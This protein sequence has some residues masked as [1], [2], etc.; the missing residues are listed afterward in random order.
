MPT[1]YFH[2]VDGEIIGESTGGVEINYS[3]DALGSVT[4][5]PGRR[6]TREHLHIQAVWGA[7]REDRRGSGPEVR[8]GGVAGVSADGAVAERLLR[9]GAAPWTANRNVDGGR[10]LWP[11]EASYCYGSA[12]PT[13]FVDPTGTQ[14][15]IFGE[16]WIE[17]FQRKVACPQAGRS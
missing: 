6:S 14:I 15:I 7:A 5:T 11:E 3:T 1:T 4:G 9:Q 17:F 2:T 16:P 13:C 12:R 8:M 10:P